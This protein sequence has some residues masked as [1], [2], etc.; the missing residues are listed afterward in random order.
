[1]LRTQYVYLKIASS[2]HAYAAV[3]PTWLRALN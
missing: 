3:V 1:M 2:L